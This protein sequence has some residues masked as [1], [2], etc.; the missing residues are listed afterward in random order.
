MESQPPGPGGNQKLF[1]IFP[2]SSSTSHATDSTLPSNRTAPQCNVK[3]L[4]RI[5]TTYSTIAAR[6]TSFQRQ[7]LTGITL[8]QLARN[9][10][11]HQFRAGVGDCTF[12]FTCEMEIYQ[13]YTEDCLWQVIC[14]DL[15]YFLHASSH[16][17]SS[18]DPSTQL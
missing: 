15:K 9:R 8:H 16:A 18:A 11:Y 3:S 17:P 10:Y 12:C 7:L 5:S 14:H 1:R 4:F 13:D 2:S 6:A